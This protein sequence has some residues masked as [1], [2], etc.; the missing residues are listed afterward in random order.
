MLRLTCLITLLGVGVAH[1]QGYNYAPGLDAPMAHLPGVRSDDWQEQQ[2]QPET[3]N[4][5]QTVQ[6]TY[7]QPD[8]YRPQYESNPSYR[9]AVPDPY[10]PMR[11]HSFGNDDD[12]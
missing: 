1:A 12:E 2:R 5:I 10:Q 6:P 3:Y 9:P 11:P 8:L 4:P 7:S